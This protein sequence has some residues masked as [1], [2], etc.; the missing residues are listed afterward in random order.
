MAT[1]NRLGLFRNPLFSVSGS[2]P[3]ERAGQSVSGLLEF[4]QEIH[5]IPASDFPL[6][7]QYFI[8]PCFTQL[9]EKI[10]YH[11]TAFS[12]SVAPKT[13]GDNFFIWKNRCTERSRRG[14]GEGHAAPGMQCSPSQIRVAKLR[15]VG[16]T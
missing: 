5:W 13:G 2:G 15:V 16:Y 8:Q 7:F 12:G 14:N 4:L 6:Q 10:Q 3:F 1:L 11:H 9:P